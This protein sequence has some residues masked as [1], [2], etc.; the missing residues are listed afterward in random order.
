MADTRVKLQTTIQLRRAVFEDTCVLAIGE[1]GYHTGTKQFKVGDGVKYYSSW[2]PVRS[3]KT[4][5]GKKKCMYY[6]RK[7]FKNPGYEIRL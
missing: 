5:N 7:D 3:I 4:L 6:K 2:S 1:P